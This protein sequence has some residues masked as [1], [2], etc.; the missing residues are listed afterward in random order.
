MRSY[1]SPSFT[2]SR[3]GFPVVATSGN[4][5]GEPICI[6]ETQALTTLA[7]IADVFLVHNRPIVRPVDD[8]IV[9]II[10]GRSSLHRIDQAADRWLR[11]YRNFFGGCTQDD[12]QGNNR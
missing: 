5:S 7:G 12:R 11:Y 6:D 9:Q 1:T 8:S 2:A 3:T 4:R 10:N